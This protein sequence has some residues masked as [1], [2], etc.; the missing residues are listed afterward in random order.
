MKCRMLHNPKGIYPLITYSFLQM[1]CDHFLHSVLANSVFH[2]P[3]DML[4]PFLF[5]IN[6]LRLEGNI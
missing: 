1:V 2:Y 5:L 6:A 3:G 4:L